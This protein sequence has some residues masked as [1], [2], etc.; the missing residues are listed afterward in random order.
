MNL[1]YKLPPG[2]SIKSVPTKDFQ[3]IWEKPAKRFF[4][5]YS[6]FPE[7]K[8]LYTTKQLQYFKHLREQFKADSHFRLNLALYYKNKCVGWSWGFQ[9]SPTIF[10]MCNSAI[11]EDHREKGLY[12]CLMREMLSQVI[13]LGFYQIYSRHHITNNAI[14]I[15]KLRQGF[16]LTTF[17]N[18]F[19]FGTMIHLTYFP[20]QI[21]NDILDFRSGYMRPNKKMK[22]V[23]KL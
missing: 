9:E 4:N 19:A 15:A 17:E 5:D 8:Y 12:T 13:P 1:K 11:F 3:K 10:Y 6:L 23:F 14:I 21:T 22:K 7:K 20:S 18:S 16:K 2:Y